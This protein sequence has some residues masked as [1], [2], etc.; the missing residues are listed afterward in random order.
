MSV[1]QRQS[2]AGVAS[3]APA[4][5][6]PALLTITSRPPVRCAKS[7]TDAATNASRET[8]PA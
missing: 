6:T 5:A 8:S 1:I 7:A 3:T 2:A 4:T